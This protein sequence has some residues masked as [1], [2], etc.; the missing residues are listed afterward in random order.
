MAEARECQHWIRFGAFEVKLGA[1][2]L[3]KYGL[4]IK[5]QDKPSQFLALLLEHPGE[6]VTREELRQRLWPADVFVDFDNNLNAAAARVRQALGDSAESPR[7]VETVARRGYRFVAPVTSVNSPG[8]ATSGVAKGAAVP[9]FPPPLAKSPPNGGVGQKSRTAPVAGT[10]RFSRR[11]LAAIGAGASMLVAAALLA[12]VYL[13]RMKAR[14]PGGDAAPIQS[15]A[16]L[17][18]ENLSGD[19]AQGYVADG[20]TEALITQLA[21]I[22]SLRVI[23][24]TSVM[25]YKGTGKPLPE[26]A[27][28]LNVDAVVEGAVARAGDRIQV[29]AQL[30]QARTDTHLWADTYQGDWRNVLTLQNSVALAIADEIRAKLTAEERATFGRRRAVEPDAYLEYLKGR[31]FWNKREPA[32]LRRAVDHFQQAI[33]KDPTYALAYSGL[34]D[35]C[36]VLGLESPGADNMVRAKAAAEKALQLDATLAEPHT[37]LAFVEFVSDWNFTAAEAEFRR[38]LDLNPGYATAHHWYAYDLLALGRPGE[39]FK[40]IRRALELDPLS[41]AIIT[42]VGEIL[43]Y[44]RRYNQAIEQYRKAL[45]IDANFFPAHLNLGYV[46]A[47]TKAYEPAMREFELAS[48][49][50]AGPLV[51]SVYA[52]AGRAFEARQVLRHATEPGNQAHVSP[53]ELALLSSSLGDD[54]QTLKWLNQAYNDRVFFMIYLGIDPRFD[55]LHSDTRFQDLVQHIGTR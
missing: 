13:G 8:D 3:R 39:A 42:D 17:P 18:L 50:P 49:L 33:A 6:I 35:S 7:Y 36:A 55:R 53:W 4:P 43:Y 9:R 21:R 11:R 14:Q 31:Y 32:E 12:G 27:R 38:A 16:V 41:L 40:E 28:E 23:S 51:G 1:G 5:L 24:R 48:R 29:T 45:D 54:N 22:H 52:L 46:Y 47:T 30:I 26:I 15:L 20:F 37:S 19:P 2:E 10:S 44:Q 25:R 34:A